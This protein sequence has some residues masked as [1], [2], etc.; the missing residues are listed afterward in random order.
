MINLFDALT[1]PLHAV[2]PAPLN[3]VASSLTPVASCLLQYI[4]HIFRVRID[5]N[6]TID[7]VG[8]IVRLDQFQALD[9][10]D[11]GLHLLGG[12][13]AEDDF[14]ADLKGAGWGVDIERHADAFLTLAEIDAGG[15]HS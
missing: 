7:V 6:R 12:V 15:P 13:G 8:E 2:R 1:L 11:E 4:Y 5:P 3:P 10:V 14:V 9:P